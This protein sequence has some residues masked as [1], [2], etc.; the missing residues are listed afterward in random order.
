MSAGTVTVRALEKCLATYGLADPRMAGQFFAAQARVQ[1]TPWLLSAVDDLR[2][3]ATAG[4]R[5]PSGRLF[6][7]YRSNLVACPDRRVGGRQFLRPMSSL[8]APRVAARV[9][10]SAMWRRLKDIGR[11]TAPNGPGMPPGVA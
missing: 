5:S 7:W 3:P 1:R 4:N 10:V 9:L 6:N 8:F 11:K 2:L